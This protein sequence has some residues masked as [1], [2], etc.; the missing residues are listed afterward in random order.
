MSVAAFLALTGARLPIVQAPMAGFAGS[1]LAIAAIRAG[2][3]GSL[4]CATL[5]PAQVLA[6]TVAIRAAASGPVNLNFFCHILPPAPDDTAWREALAQFYAAEGVSPPIAAPALRRPFDAAML[7]AVERLRPGIVSFHFGL[8]DALLLARV[9]ATGA[10]VFGNATN[11]DEAQALAARGCDA[12]VAQGFEAGGHAGHFLFGHQP[13]GLSALL[14]AIVD[15]VDV[16]VIAAGGIGDARG[17]A[18]ARALGAAAVQA[19]TAYLLS[20][21]TMTSAA[22]RARLADATADDSLFTTLFSGRAARGLRNR[23]IETL[24]A[25]HDA[26]PPFPYASAA[27]APLRAKA[28]AEGRGDYSPL[29]AGQG[30]ALARAEPAETITRRLGMAALHGASA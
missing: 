24:G 18:A 27:L 1:A 11:L 6:E 30:V 7:D 10:K 3:V 21:E 19:G 22:H 29:W 12:I 4:A 15:T 26:V 13:V 23:L 16:P 2:G 14:P 8:P 25:A 9:K 17:V 5:D 20:P 28:E